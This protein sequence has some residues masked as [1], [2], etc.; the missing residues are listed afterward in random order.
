MIMGTTLIPSSSARKPNANYCDS[1][2][3]LAAIIY[4]PSS[5]RQ[6][7]SHNHNFYFYVHSWCT[8]EVRPKKNGESTRM[9]TYV[10]FVT[11][12]IMSSRQPLGPLDSN[13][14]KT[15]RSA[16]GSVSPN[17]CQHSSQLEATK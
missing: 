12:N 15:E 8:E 11:S 14:Y 5:W 13:Q 1:R 16:S 3:W 7:E 10:R 6:P 9:S 4:A 2:R 17:K